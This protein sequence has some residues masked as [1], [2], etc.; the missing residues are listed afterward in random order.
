MKKPS[1][2]EEEYF[3][4]QDAEKRRKLALEQQRAMAAAERDRLRQLHQMRCPKCGMELT[5]I[6]YRDV[7][8]DRCFS[9][10]GT[11][12]DEGELEQLAGREPG[13]LQ[14]LISVFKED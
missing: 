3:A 10:G 8:I 4:R 6:S 2:T 5:T 12:L 7:Q 14:K 11:W 1:E 9:C 13:F